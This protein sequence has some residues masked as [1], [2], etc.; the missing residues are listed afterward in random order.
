MFGCRSTD[1]SCKLLSD[2]YIQ[3]P[4]LKTPANDGPIFLAE[5]HS[6]VLRAATADDAKQWVELISE[7]KR[8]YDDERATPQHTNEREYSR[9]HAHSHTHAH[10]LTLTDSRMWKSIRRRRIPMMKLRVRSFATKSTTAWV[11][12]MRLTT[13]S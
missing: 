3:F 9:A 1:R 7:A 5:T 6:L 4:R 10:S 13:S 2:L 12:A 11:L 8:V